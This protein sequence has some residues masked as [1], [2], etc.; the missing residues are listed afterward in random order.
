MTLH[1][2]Y[3]AN[4]YA[5]KNAN[6]NLAYCVKSQQN[7]YVSSSINRS[8]LTNVEKV[9]KRATKKYIAKKE[10]EREKYRE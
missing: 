10:R 4:R 9:V 7:E 2:V 6:V 5:I 3:S 8:K 1:N